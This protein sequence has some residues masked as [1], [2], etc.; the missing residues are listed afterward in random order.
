MVCTVATIFRVC[1]A[2]IRSPYVR[3]PDLEH[4]V[5]E[6]AHRELRAD[7]SYPRGEGNGHANG[8]ADAGGAVG[9]GGHAAP[10]ASGEAGGAA[11]EPQP[12]ILVVED[13]E[14]AREALGELLRLYGYE[15][16]LAADG[17]QGVEMAVRSSPDVALVDI[18]LPGLDGYQV[19]RRVREHL[20]RGV[21]LVAMTGYG[22]ADDRRRAR[23]AGFDHHL[24]KPVSPSRLLELLRRPNDAANRGQDGSVERSR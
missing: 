9:G 10:E 15:V 12:R 8:V 14:D 22:Q 23:E 5:V 2:F 19:A 17:P 21:F 13:L 1:R 3:K 16:E 18:G 4:G 20:G 7:P 24:V 6:L 11:A